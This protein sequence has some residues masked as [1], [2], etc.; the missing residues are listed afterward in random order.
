MPILLVF[1]EVVCCHLANRH[2]RWLFVFYPF[3]KWFFL[4][5]LPY[6]KFHKLKFLKLNNHFTTSLSKVNRIGL[7]DISILKSEITWLLQLWNFLL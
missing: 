2:R 6:K 7:G 1:S 3:L 4:P 5:F